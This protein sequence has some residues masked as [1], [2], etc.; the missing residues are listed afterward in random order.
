MNPVKGSSL[1]LFENILVELRNP[2]QIIISPEEALEYAKSAGVRFIKL[3]YKGNSKST[4]KGWQPMVLTISKGKDGIRLET[5]GK[6]E[7]NG[8]ECRTGRLCFIPDKLGIL[9][10]YVPT[11]DHNMKLLAACYVNDT[12]EWVFVDKEDEKEIAELTK[13][14][15]VEY[16]WSTEKVEKTTASP[17]R[18]QPLSKSQGKIEAAVKE[19]TANAVKEITAILP[20]VKP[21]D[22]KPIR[23]DLGFK[24]RVEKP[25]QTKEAKIDNNTSNNIFKG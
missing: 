6:T 4:I 7:S 2:S 9:W 5:R 24:P 10:G 23:E 14:Y 8:R 16:G 22:S 17:Y 21:I 11:T 18:L 1:M 3:R 12:S 20:P 13:K 19:A 25:V 15:I